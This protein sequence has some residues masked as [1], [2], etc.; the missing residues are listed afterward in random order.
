[1]LLPK[2]VSGSTRD[3]HELFSATDRNA[4]LRWSSPGVVSER[5]VGLICELG[6]VVVRSVPR[7]ALVSRAVAR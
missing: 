1:M 2:Q 7:V 4:Q 3:G 5:A 6:E